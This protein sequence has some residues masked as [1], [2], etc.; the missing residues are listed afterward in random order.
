VLNAPKRIVCPDAATYAEERKTDVG[1]ISVA[2]QRISLPGRFLPGPSRCYPRRVRNRPDSPLPAAA[3]REGGCVDEVSVC[4]ARLA[5][6]ILVLRARMWE[7]PSIAAAL[8]PGDLLPGGSTAPGCGGPGLLAL[9][10]L[11]L[12]VRLRRRHVVRSTERMPSRLR[13]SGHADY[14]YDCISL[15]DCGSSRRR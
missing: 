1:L 13:M 5:A 14:R 15:P 7:A 10:P 4:V 2:L 12:G 9:L 8:L 11:R 3:E 6:D